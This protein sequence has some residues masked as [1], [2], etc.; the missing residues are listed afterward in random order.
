MISDDEGNKWIHTEDLGYVDEQVFL[1]LLGRMKRVMFIGPEG[2]AYKVFP[3]QIEDG[4]IKI[5]EVLD[6]CCKWT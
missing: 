6:V 1:F 2:L 4:I 3:K 5:P